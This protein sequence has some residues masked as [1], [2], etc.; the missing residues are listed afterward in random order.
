[1]NNKTKS[2]IFRLPA[3]ILLVLIALVPFYLKIKNIYPMS[4][5]TPITLFLIAVAYFYGKY[6]QNKDSFNF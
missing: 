2:F 1:M 6:L 5:P 3:E 4:W